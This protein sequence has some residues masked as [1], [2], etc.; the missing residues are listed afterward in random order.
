MDFLAFEEELFNTLRAYKAQGKSLCSTSSFQTQS[1]PLLHLLSRFEDKIPV[2]FI[3]T[4]FHFPETYQYVKQLKDRLQLDVVEVSSSS[5]KYFQ[6]DSHGLFLYN[7]DPDRCCHI[8]K[9]EPL[10]TGLNDYDV[11]IAGVRRD[12]TA[13]RSALNKEELIRPGLLKYHP[14]LEWNSKLVYE[15]IRTHNLP[16]HPLEEKGYFSVG[17]MPCTVNTALNAQRDGR[18]YGKNKKECGIHLK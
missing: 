7:T 11:W 6:R 16:K 1:L 14:M 15:Y 3:D 9:T 4:G 18:W 10:H 12:Q 5:E 17:C 13:H 2:L 8:N